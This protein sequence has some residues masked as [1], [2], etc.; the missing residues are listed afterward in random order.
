[1]FKITMIVPYQE[2]IDLAIETLK[3]H[4]EYQASLNI[5]LKKDEYEF[6]GIVASNEGVRDLKL[7]ADVIIARGYTAD[8]LKER[9]PYIPIVEIPVAGNDLIRCI[10][11][12]KEL[13]GVE[14]VAVIGSKNMIFGAED[15]SSIV[16]IGVESLLIEKHFEA[17]KLA[18]LAKRMGHKA[19][20]SGIT[21][22]EHARNIGLHAIFI[23]TGKESLWQA[24]TE[25]KRIADISRKDQERAELLNKILNHSNEGVI[26]VDKKNRIS[27]VN[28][29]AKK[30]LKMQ[31]V[32]IMDK[33]T[34]AIFQMST[35]N[36]LISKEGEYLDEIVRYEGV[37]LA[38]NKVNIN[39]KGE[40]AGSLLIFQDV[41]G[42]QERE[43][44]IRNKIYARG[45]VAKHTFQDII[46]NS[47]QIKN[48]IDLARSIS[49]VDSNILIV[50]ETGTGKEVFAQSIHNYSLRNKGPFVAVNCAA[51][52]ENLLE[53]ELFGY[54]EGAFTGA[55][56]GGKPGLFELAH[57]GTIF[58]D[59][60]GE[61]SEK[62]QSRLLRVIQEKEIMRLGGDRVIPV[63]ARIISATNKDLRELITRGEFREDLYY[64]LNVLK[65]KLPSLRERKE[66]IRLLVEHFIKIYGIY[67]GKCNTL[68]IDEAV[69]VLE[70]LD[71]HGNI[72]ELANMCERLVVLNRTDIIDEQAVQRIL[73]MEGNTNTISQQ[74]QENN[75]ISCEDCKKIVN[76]QQIG[77]ESIEYALQK[78][79][80]NKMKTAKYLGVS[81]STLYNY[82]K[83]FDI[84]T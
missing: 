51:L 47:A 37:Q 39:V 12:C 5:G 43:G 34:D 55:L 19:V 70:D 45:L 49:K 29:A 10:Y 61:I 31:E 21:V 23:K 84:T 14:K 16:G 83:E 52:P 30:I 28:S 46:G 62:L 56:K 53:S 2:L 81:R 22:C 26:A 41:T 4:D 40:D 7:N 18:D 1:M 66:D 3:E 72:R 63:D 67:F 15:L 71:F 59:E 74:K 50:G 25:A 76:I 48:C 58:L 65:I 20:I 24:I 33:N 44:K 32:N 38:V 77:R 75:Q 36:D 27:A 64:R 79:K 13:Y 8:L 35:F 9:K 78:M 57:R 82:I 42:I 6:R 80:Y 69:R 60:I 54:M 73:L 11:E 68:I 17:Y